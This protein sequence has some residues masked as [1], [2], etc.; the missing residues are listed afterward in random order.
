LLAAH[1]ATIHLATSGLVVFCGAA[2]V[3]KEPLPDMIAYS[4]SKTG[5]HSLALTL[6]ESFNKKGSQQ[7]TITIL[8]ETIDTESNRIAMPKADFT[9]WSKPT[10]IG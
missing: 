7:K 3:F 1:L 10:Q 2:S 4:I 9:K 5:V 8:P 6:A